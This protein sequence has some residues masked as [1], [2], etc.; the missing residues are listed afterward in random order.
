MQIALLLTNNIYSKNVA[1]EWERQVY[2][3]NIKS[4]N[5]ALGNDYHTTMDGPMEGIPYNQDLIDRI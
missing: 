4:F 1:E 2:I 5:Y 3:R